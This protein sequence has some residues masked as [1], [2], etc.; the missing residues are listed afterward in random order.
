M[1]VRASVF[2]VGET[3]IRP[4]WAHGWVFAVGH[5]SRNSVTTWKSQTAGS[6]AACAT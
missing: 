5:R 1:V 2:D 3:L 4:R 6:V